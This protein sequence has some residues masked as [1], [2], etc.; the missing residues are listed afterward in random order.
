MNR[1]LQIG[2]TLASA[3][4]IGWPCALNGANITMTASDGGG[5]TSFNAAGK[6]S[7]AAA[8]SAANDYFTAGYLL[9][10][11]ATAAGS[12]NYFLGNSLSLDFNAGNLL[13]G[14]A[15]KY[16][17]SSSVR[18]DN[19]KLNGGGI[20]NGVGGTMSVYGNITVLTNS[21]LD[22]QASGRILAIYA[23][24]SGASTNTIGIRAA[25]GSAGGVVQL[26]GDASA[27]S[28][29][30]KTWGIG[31]SA[32]GAAL[33]VGNG[34]TTGNL[35]SG[36]VTNDYALWFNRSDSITVSNAISG[37]GYV[38]MAGSGTLALLGNN[39]YTGVTTN[40]TG[41][42]NFASLGNLGT[43]GITLGGGTLQFA[44]GN[45]ADIS[46][47]TVTLNGTGGTLD[48]GTN[49]VTL[50]N[51]IGNS[52]PGGLTKAGSGRLTLG[53]LNTYAGSTTVNAGTLVV[54]AGSSLANSPTV[55]VAAGATLDLS[56]VGG[57]P[58]ASGQTLAGS[59][60]VVG[61]LTSLAGV[62]VSPGGTNSG[63]LTFNGNLT[64]GGG[65]VR[66]DLNAPNVVGGT[67]DLL[68]VNGNL[69]LTPGVTL[70][71]F[72]PGGIPVRGTYTLCQC[73]G[74]LTGDPSYLNASLGNYSV[75]FA[76]NTTASPRT[77]TMT[78]AGLPQSLRWT[79][80]NSADWDTT[81]LN[82]TNTVGLTNT[83][84][85][86]GD[87]VRLDDTAV[88]TAINVT[89]V[90]APGQTTVDTAAMY[91]LF[92]AAGGSLAGPGGVVKTGPGTLILDLT[93]TYAGPTTIQGGVVQIGNADATGTFGQGPVTNNASIVLARGDTAGVLPN[94]IS[95]TGGITSAGG[96]AVTLGGSNSFTG[97]TVINSGAIRVG[98]PNALGGAN[99]SVT[100]TDS[101]VLDLNGQ[102]NVPVSLSVLGS[103]QGAGALVNNL[104]T[105]AAFNGTVTLT[106]DTTVGGSGALTVNAPLTGPFALSKLG[107]G[108]TLLTAA[109]AYSGGTTVNAGVLGVANG[110][111]LGSGTVTV[112]SGNTALQL[113]GGIVVSGL[114]LINN[115]GTGGANGLDSNT[116]SNV[117]AGPIT[118]GIDFARFGG[119]VNAVLNLTGAV[120]D[121][122]NGFGFR[123]RGIDGSGTVQFSATNTYLGNTSIDVG[124]L[125]LAS[126]HAL[127]ITTSVGVN[128]LSGAV[129]DL[130]GYSAQTIGLT[131]IGL[132]TNSA[133]TPST[134][135]LNLSN[136]VNY[137]T[138]DGVS[139]NN[140]GP[141]SNNFFG[142]IGGNVALTK[143]GEAGT[144]LW[145]T[146]VQTYSG[147]TTI[148]AGTLALS[149]TASLGG[150]S[151]LIVA[152]GAVLDASALSAG[153]TLGA[154]QTIQGGGLVLGNVSAKGT[155]APGGPFATLTFT[156]NLLLQAGSTT[157]VEVRPDGACDQVVCGG[158]LTYGGALVVTN[159]GGALTTNNV[160]KLFTAG[161]LAGAFSSVTP[162]P[163]VGLVW[164]TNTLPLDGTLRIA[165]GVVLT[166]TNLTAVV[167]GG[168]TLQ[169][170]WP[171]DHLGW[172]LQA[173]TNTASVGLSTN[174]FKVPGSSTT[175]LLN[176]PIDPANPTVFFRMVYP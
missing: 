71:T 171:A 8:P 158:T 164:N 123:V 174:W 82:W 69:T 155:I 28:G 66:Y 3:A 25:S 176:L 26:L 96:G 103:G 48:L 68:V 166:R 84:F 76:L 112:N 75:T 11:P 146:N 53:G 124:V 61:S 12:S 77:V 98:N 151:N 52:G 115:N 107:A 99:A 142:V 70:S 42:L 170:S 17:G 162:P 160:F 41:I 37:P 74:T 135:T 127:P 29:N 131:G 168:N 85:S 18:V 121:G 6:W 2:L 97:G 116:G 169:L 94:A 65:T 86:P 55:T 90:M 172:S 81:T 126:A 104:G 27:Y 128:N 122:G 54:G 108:T 35:G 119:G 87:T 56:A 49:N 39:T 31:D 134:L 110:A 34:G 4:A 80:Q 23:A 51:P 161:D 5:A 7:N 136:A 24:I 33:Q 91:T 114:S 43:G 73:T 38:V 139:Y 165:S 147:S 101:G 59:G 32:P 163:G 150:S 21:Y 46:T 167:I 129:F 145:L 109:N 149:P 19:L 15:I 14:L 118:L 13:V 138:L 45:T 141:G 89:G 63:T 30:W 111:A 137:L 113:N 106:G 20:F 88:Q 16:A 9:R 44:P 57:T 72:F 144:V 36:N 100:V 156:N 105:A 120:D 133:G 175:N 95:G 140:G 79:G 40:N 125:R 62:L 83:I 148:A 173:Q 159:L 143:A 1:L 78:V 60:T 93:N 47:L 67:N 10:T 92:T 132:V 58:L 50:A 154:A 130:A 152:S 64:L 157:A 117:W 102:T 22:P 153:F